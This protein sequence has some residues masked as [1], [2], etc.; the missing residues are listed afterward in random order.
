MGEDA[1][2]IQKE[3]V[4]IGG[5]NV[6]DYVIA[7]IVFCFTPLLAA[8]HIEYNYEVWVFSRLEIRRS[9]RHTERRGWTV[10][11]FDS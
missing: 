3:D 10:N 1:F 7:V 9:N 11:K 8:V 6:F 2:Q 4:S 5:E